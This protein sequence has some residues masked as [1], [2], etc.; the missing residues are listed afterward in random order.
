MSTKITINAL[1]PRRI[2][3]TVTPGQ[4]VALTGYFLSTVYRWIK[5]GEIKAS[6]MGP[7]LWH[8]PKSELLR[9]LGMEDMPA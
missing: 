9:A 6:K 8:I 1:D 7:K 4:F 3:P 5:E 2:S